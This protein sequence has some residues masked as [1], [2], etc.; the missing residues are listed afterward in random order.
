MS[1]EELVT[2]QLKPGK[3]V[4]A[5]SGG[6]DSV[7]LLDIA[8]KLKDI[9][10]VVAHLDHGIRSDSKLDQ[11]LVR[12]LAKKYKLVYE[13]KSVNLGPNA[14]E[15]KARDARYEFLESVLKANQADA[16]ITA[17]HQ[18]D[19]IETSIINLIR[20]SGRSGLTSLKSSEKLIRPL[21]GATKEQI[22]LYATDHN[23]AWREDSTNQDLKFRRNFIRHRLQNLTDKSA[24]KQL[25]KQISNLRS[26]NDQLDQELN[27]LLVDISQGN[28]LMRNQFI[29]LSHSLSLELMAYWLRQNKIL[30]FDTKLLNNLVIAAKTYKPHT[31]FSV[32]KTAYLMI[33][34]KFLEIK[35]DL[36]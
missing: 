20:G 12:N 7:T 18:D 22:S 26:T 29:N 34:T 16:I 6:V 25:Y 30:S 11:E 8:S 21:L 35:T 23:L 28:Q 36:T 19:A 2:K 15:E 17:H 14:S 4:I 10:I 33:E 31:K 1:I 32:N 27:Q 13:T 5:V 3:Y 9:E 24:V